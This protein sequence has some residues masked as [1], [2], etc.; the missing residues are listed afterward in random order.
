M[1]FDTGQ[2]NRKA[3]QPV[4]KGYAPKSKPPSFDIRSFKIPSS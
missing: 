4:N 1:L 2:K 3:V